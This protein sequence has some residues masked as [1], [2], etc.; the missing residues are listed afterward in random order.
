MRR[1]AL[2]GNCCTTWQQTL[3]CH[4]NSFACFRQRNIQNL[5]SYFFPSGLAAL[6]TRRETY[7]YAEEPHVSA[8]HLPL[9]SVQRLYQPTLTRPPPQKKK[10]VTH[11]VRFF[12]SLFPPSQSRWLYGSGCVSVLACAAS[13]PLP[14]PD[15]NS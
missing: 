9:D 14:S 11:H 8:P 1:N 10:I 2:R 15:C 12:A 7:T 6:C 5:A 13:R 3:K 4:I